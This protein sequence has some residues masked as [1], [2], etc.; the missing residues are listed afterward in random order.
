MAKTYPFN[1]NKHQHDI[2]YC[3]NRAKNI[4]DYEKAEEISG[5]LRYPAK[6]VWL[7]GKELG[8]A[9]NCAIWADEMRSAANKNR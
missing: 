2:F 3:Y 9:K 8:L 6:V 4:G 1:M 7:T 5:L